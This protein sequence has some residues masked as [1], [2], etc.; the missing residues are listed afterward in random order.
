MFQKTT[1]GFWVI[2]SFIGL[3]AA[4]PPVVLIPGKYDVLLKVCNN[5][6]Q[7]AASQK[8]LFIIQ[9]VDRRKAFGLCG[10]VLVF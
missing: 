5:C 3:V 8:M 9:C 7:C 6:E 2:L 1:F 4:A 10:S